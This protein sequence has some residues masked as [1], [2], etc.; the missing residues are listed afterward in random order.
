MEVINTR[1]TRQEVKELIKQV[2]SAKSI[3]DLEYIAF[4]LEMEFK[5]RELE[6][7]GNPQEVFL[8]GFCDAMGEKQERPEMTFAEFKEISCRCA[9]LRGEWI[10]AGEA[11][12]KV[13]RFSSSLED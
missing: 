11:T 8:R 10:E 6:R 7:S 1:V 13:S 2:N 9:R 4:D 12:P 5:P 3:R